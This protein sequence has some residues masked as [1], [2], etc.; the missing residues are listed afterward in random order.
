MDLFH[1][2]LPLTTFVFQKL[3][4]VRISKFIP[5]PPPVASGG[6]GGGSGE[7]GIVMVTSKIMDEQLTQRVNGQ[8]LE[9]SQ[10]QS[11]S[12]FQ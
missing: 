1:D 2:T 12:P 7:M 5:P 6:G 3:S 11:K 10:S 4:L 8:L 9:V